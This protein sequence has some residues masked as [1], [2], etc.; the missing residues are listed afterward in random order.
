[1][2]A[3]PPSLSHPILCLVTDRRQTGGR[4]LDQV[5]ALA[6][7]GGVNMVQLRE[8]DLPSGQLMD[9]ALSLRRLTK[10][11]AL[12]FIND[13]VDVAVASGADGVQL[14]E[15]A[16]AVD[17]ARRSGPGLLVSRSVHDFDGAV[18]A[19]RDGADMLVAG[20]IFL[21]A[22]HPGARPAGV[23]L[24]ERLRTEVSLPYIAIGGVTER[25]APAAIDAG[26]SGVAVIGAIARSQDPRCAARTLSTS[27]ADAVRETE[28]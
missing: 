16:M 21:S 3:T 19:E 14:G 4:P 15:N 5:V 6:L 26:A 22:S 24:L 13:R 7:C 27:I 20:T 2:P 1:M 11:R 18:R 25:N 8:K 17:A 28:K 12:L 9:L 23:E 10:G